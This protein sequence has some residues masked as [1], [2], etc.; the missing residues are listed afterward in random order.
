[1]LDYLSSR[2]ISE[3]EAVDKI[4]PIGKWRDDYNFAALEALIM[5]VVLQLYGKK[6]RTHK[7]LHPADFIPDW[8]GD[9]ESLKKADPEE[10]KRK[11]LQ[12][13]AEHNK[14]VERKEKKKQ[15]SKAKKQ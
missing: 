6:G 7:Q 14:Q 12:W 13:A 10:L 5:S 15:D 8:A 9:G 2:Q 11:L 4:D 1:L 3:W